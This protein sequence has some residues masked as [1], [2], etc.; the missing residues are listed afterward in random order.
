[1]GT[2]TFAVPSLQALYTNSAQNDWQIVAVVSQPDRPSGRGRNLVPPPVKVA[3]T[4]L[5]VP[6]MQPDKLT[7][8]VVAEL[9]TYAPDLIVVAAF[10]QILRKRILNLP[11][12]GCLNVH[13]SLLPRWRGAAP[14]QAA[15]R[16]GDS[17]TGI[18][19]MQ[20][21]P[22]LD[23]GPMLARRAIPITSDHT[24]GT[25]TEALAVLGGQL[26]VESLP[27]W[28]A[29]EIISQPQNEA[30][31]T[32]APQLKKEDG[33]IDWHQSA[34][35]IERQVRAYAPWPGTYTTGPRGLLKI[36]DVTTTDLPPEN[37]E[38]GTVFKQN[39][40]PCVATGE[41][42]IRLVT[43]QPAGKKLMS[44]RA[45]MNGQPELWQSTLGVA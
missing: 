32:Y 38:P 34:L 44:A 13:A 3:A 20:M 18:T 15:I 10:G 19:L 6:V 31:A 39:K 30:L 28:L 24:G 43:V 42:A 8:A 1:M 40:Q 41:G 45:M 5:G 23:T 4:T 25:L 26:L 35:E 36:I 27:A 17:E 22:G 12:Y 11:K 2:P 9:A 7:R 37:F 33:A 14:V 21:D 16:A 29:G